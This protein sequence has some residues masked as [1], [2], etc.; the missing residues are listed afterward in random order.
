MPLT[1][2]GKLR[3]AQA[4]GMPECSPHH[5]FQRKPP[6]SDP[7]M[8]HGTC[9]THKPW[10][11]SGSLPRGGGENLPGIL[12]AWATCNYMYLA[13]GPWQVMIRRNKGR[14]HVPRYSE[15]CCYQ[16]Q[17]DRTF[18]NVIRWWI[19]LFSCH[20]KASLYTKQHSR[21]CSSCRS[22]D[23]KSFLYNNSGFK[24]HMPI[25]FS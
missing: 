3:V 21:H 16:H 6:V 1:S 12:G 23:L 4:L 13:K 5:R 9:V 25:M 24:W 7:S 18:F 20:Q 22:Q 2:H 19:T 14:E 15:M 8:H 10:F 11:M 17:Y